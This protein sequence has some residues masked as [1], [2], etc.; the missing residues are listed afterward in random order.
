MIATLIEDPRVQALLA[1]PSGRALISQLAGRGGEGASWTPEAYA[2]AKANVQA[3]LIA[4]VNL[5]LTMA[6]ANRLENFVQSGA[7]ATAQ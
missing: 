6:I 2:A 4:C 3:S 7:G 1:Q 5:P